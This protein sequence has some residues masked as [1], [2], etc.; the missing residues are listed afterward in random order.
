LK[1]ST[2]IP[3]RL[4][5]LLVFVG[6]ALVGLKLAGIGPFGSWAWW[7]VAAPLV[8][9]AGWWWYA[10][11][12]GLNKRREVARME[13][14]KAKRRSSALEQIGQGPDARAER[15][16]EEKLLAAKQR[17]A[18]KVEGKRAA[19]RQK[20]RDSVLG[21]RFDTSQFQDPKP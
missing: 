16:K 19:Q 6:F 4:K 7:M 17:E 2:A 9:A 14:R 20:L 18:E 21:S 13:E 5:L 15:R 8:G 11:R 3:E 10:D 1:G 12:S